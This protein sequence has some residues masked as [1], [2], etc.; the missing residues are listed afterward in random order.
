MPLTSSVPVVRT[1]LVRPVMGQSNFD[2][3][4]E[5][6]IH[7]SPDMQNCSVG[8]GMLMKRPGYTQFPSGGA[9]LSAD[10]VVGLYSTQDDENNTY[11]YAVTPTG[12]WRWNSLT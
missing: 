10:G 11:L 5:V 7:H 6:S 8:G 4:E 1:L 9:S 12:V 2:P 3:A